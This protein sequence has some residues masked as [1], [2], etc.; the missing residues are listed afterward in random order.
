MTTI[1]GPD[2]PDKEKGGGGLKLPKFSLPKPAQKPGTAVKLGT[3]PTEDERPIIKLNN[4]LKLQTEI[5]DLIIERYRKFIEEGETKSIAELRLLVRPNDAAV[6]ELKITICDQFHP[7]IYEKNFLHAVQKSLDIL[8]S[9][10]KVSLPVSFWMAFSDMTRLHA[11][12][13]IDRAIL[14]CSLMR[15]LGSDNAMVLIGKDKT[16]WVTFEF[17]AKRYVVDIESRSMSAF[18]NDDDAYKSFLYNIEYS[19]N[20][21]EYKDLTEG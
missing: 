5:A 3:Q 20:D 18:G 15:C 10:K 21:K 7:Y 4:E 12:D 14:I 6:T 1:S 11:A 17:E 8:L 19:F 16:A 9:Y 2:K 13:D